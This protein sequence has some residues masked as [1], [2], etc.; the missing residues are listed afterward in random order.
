[1]SVPT[2]R[3]RRLGGK[4]RALRGEFTLE[5][6]AEKS[7]GLFN[8]SKLSRI[9]GAKT[10][11]KPADVNALLDLYGS[12]GR[13]VDEDFRAALIELTKEGAKRGWWQSYRAVLSPVYEDLISLED[14]ATSFRTWQMGLIPGLLQTGDYA[15]EFMTRIG[16]SDAI[17]ERIDAL[18]EVRLARQAVLTRREDPM[19][20]WAIIGEEALHT[21]CGEGVMRDQLAR[22][23][24]MARRPNVTLQV[25]P[26]GA[27]PHVGQ[28]GSYSVL[29]FQNHPDLDVVY[30]E[31]LTSA[32]YV[33]DPGQVDVYGVAFEQL[34]AAALS[35]ELSAERIAKIRNEHDHDH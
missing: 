12:L 18:V 14:E 11:A 15:R 20:L 33:E 30:L 24:A 26:S 17:E 2:V 8:V 35:V 23:L 32:L 6:I 28:M 25:L 29:G 1:M 3:R 4:L 10:A 34:R 31:N 9:E 16:M 7:G 27:G 21:R 22:L 5:E 13:P 19:T